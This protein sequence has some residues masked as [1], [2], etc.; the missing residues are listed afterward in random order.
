MP[1]WFD[2]LRGPDIRRFKDGYNQ[3]WQKMTPVLSV[4][5]ESGQL[6]WLWL[7]SWNAARNTNLLRDNKV[8]SRMS[9]LGRPA[10][11]HRSGIKDLLWYDM[12]RIVGHGGDHGLW[13]ELQG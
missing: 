6:V 13:P 9:M 5:T 2:H 7:G 12:N 3:S 11:Q 8:R 10:V 4:I 1:E